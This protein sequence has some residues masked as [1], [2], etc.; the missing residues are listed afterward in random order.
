MILNFNQIMELPKIRRLNLINSI[1]GIKPANMIGTA[2][3]KGE[4]NLAIF[5]SVVHLGSKPPLIGFILRPYSD[6]RRHTWENIEANGVYTI[7]HVHQSN[8]EQAHY[9]S[10]KFEA[11]ESEF[12]HCHFTPEYIYGFKAP[13]VLESKIKIGLSFHS[14]IPIPANNTTL[15]IGKIEHLIVPDEVVQENGQINL[16]EAGGTGISGLN[17]YYDLSYKEEFPYARK[18]ELPEFL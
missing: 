3:E 8:I 18:S 12:S 7:N 15:V 4:N 6:V 17:C 10:A 16:A 5:S 11:D 1:T 13:F 14:A 2:N 9:T